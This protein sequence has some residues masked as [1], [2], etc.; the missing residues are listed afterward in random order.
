MMMLNSA[1]DSNSKFAVTKLLNEIHC[2]TAYMSANNTKGSLCDYK[3][4]KPSLMT[5]VYNKVHMD[6]GV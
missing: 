6:L 3:I 4:R 5:A 1:S 2:R